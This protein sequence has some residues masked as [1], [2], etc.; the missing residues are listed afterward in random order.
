[1]PHD[2]AAAASAEVTIRVE[3]A[4]KRF[5]QFVAVDDVSLDIL[6]GEVFGLIG[7]NG[8]ILPGLSLR[9]GY[10]VRPFAAFR[11]GLFNLALGF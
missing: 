5:D 8:L 9:Q 1:M 6:R 11:Q 2:P 3:Q 7:H 10:L 4:V